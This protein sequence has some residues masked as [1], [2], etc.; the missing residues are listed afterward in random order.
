VTANGKI[1]GQ[2]ISDATLQEVVR[3]IKRLEPAATIIP[4][5]SRV[6][7]LAFSSG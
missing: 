6:L 4:K 7:E 5:T 2:D 3:E 1:V